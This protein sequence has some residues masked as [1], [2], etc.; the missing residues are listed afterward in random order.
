MQGELL[1][2]YQSCIRIAKWE[3]HNPF[4]EKSMIGVMIQAFEHT[5]SDQVQ[6]WSRS[7][8]DKLRRALKL[9]AGVCDAWVSY[10]SIRAMKTV[11]ISD[12]V[13]GFATSEYSWCSM[14]D[15]LSKHANH[16][17]AQEMN[18]ERT[19]NLVS[20]RCNLGSVLHQ[21]PRDVT[22]HIF[23]SPRDAHGDLCRDVIQRL[24]SQGHR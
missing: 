13:A 20:A 6:R 1:D 5:D 24:K 23:W 11:I 15:L 3:K 22:F 19:L 2:H 16:Q 8:H 9:Q 14:A 18:K 7:V 12:V 10:S 4:L 17:D 21:A